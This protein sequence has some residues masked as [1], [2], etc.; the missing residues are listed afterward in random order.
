MEATKKLSSESM[1]A[2]EALMEALVLSGIAMSYVGNSRPASGS[3][4]HISHFWEMDFL[5]HGKAPILHGTKVGVGTVYMLQQ[6]HALNLT[7]E[8]LEEQLVR[9]ETYEFQQ[10]LW[11]HEIQKVYG[12]AAE[13]VIQVEHSVHKNGK[14][15][16]IRRVEKVKEHL[17]EIQSIIHE[18]PDEKE[19]IEVLQVLD[20]PY[21]IAGIGVSEELLANGIRYAKEL[22]N[23]YGILQALFDIEFCT[24]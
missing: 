3:E 22:R 15:N 13:H 20:A 7:L 23:R 4:H 5:Q 19:I 24:M 18:L 21:D 11:E 17:E 1:D 16:V 2:Y 8:K 12:S 9:L 10:P 14:E 6:Y